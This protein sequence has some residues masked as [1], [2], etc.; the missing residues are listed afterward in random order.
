M[1]FPGIVFDVDGTLVDSN[2]AHARAFVDTFHSFGYEVAFEK[3]RPL[4]GTGSDR[5]IPE[6]IG[7]YEEA[8]AGRKKTIFLERHLPTVRGFPR[9]EPLLQ[10]LKAKGFKLAVASS[11]AKDELDALLALTGAR[12]CFD[13]QTDAEDVGRSKPDPDV[14]RVA[15]SKLGL[16]PDRCVMVGDTPYDAAAARAAGVAFI[17][18]R[19][20]GWGDRDLQPAAGVFRD[21]ADLLA[22]IDSWTRSNRNRHAV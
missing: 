12:D 9:V 20:G 10:T 5:L 11:A 4:I 18:L 14:V 6:L 8:V 21:P 15:L 19:C 17:G 13:Q 2:D 1:N 16:P 3:V 7:R 22:N